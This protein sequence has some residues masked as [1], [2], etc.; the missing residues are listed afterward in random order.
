MKRQ[1]TI[2]FLLLVLCVCESKAAT[3]SI[4]VAIDTLCDGWRVCVT[5]NRVGGGITDI[6]LPYATTFNVMFGLTLDPNTDGFVTTVDTPKTFCFQIFRQTT[7]RSS[8]IQLLIGTTKGVITSTFHGEPRY[9]LIPDHG[10]YHVFDSY[11]Y[12]V[13]SNY[14]FSLR[15]PDIYTKAITVKEISLVRNDTCFS[16]QTF[17]SNLPVT[18]KYGESVDIELEYH[19]IRAG[20]NYDSL[21]IVT[22]CDT[23]YMSFWGSSKSGTIQAFDINFDSLYVGEEK[24]D[25]I[26][27]QNTSTQTVNIRNITITGN[28]NMGISIIDTISMPFDLN[29]SN[30]VA[31]TV[32]YRPV[33]ASVRDSMQIKWETDID[34]HFLQYMKD[35]SIVIGSAKLPEVKWDARKLRFQADSTSKVF[36]TLNFINQAP[37]GT[38]VKRFYISGPDADEFEI[39]NSLLPRS[40]VEMNRDESDWFDIAFKPDMMK[41][42]SERYADRHAT[43]VA[44][45]KDS[46]V[47]TELLGTFNPL[48]VK[49]DLALHDLVINPNPMYGQDATLSFTLAEE[50]Q[51]SISIYDILGR[52]VRSIPTEY[53]SSGSFSNTIHTSK[54]ADG[55][56]ILRVS[57]GSSTKS[58]SF[59]VVR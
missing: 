1:V 28:E 38:Q 58:I 34:P 41:P 36:R 49:R 37:A 35:S 45:L 56:Y 15:A 33:K 9:R 16:V 13:R 32:K 21:M 5:D 2:L 20:W 30:G 7:Y 39:F 29:P 26:F 50:K 24:H 46:N 4:S 18:L 52:E 3:D 59:R 42:P 47:T 11:E 22:D 44:E 14:N 48:N 19:A 25:A 57:D 6:T 40:N 51:L 31:L 43:L 27:V 12:D 17:P 54:L 55:S 23:T 53:Y 8:E 10:S